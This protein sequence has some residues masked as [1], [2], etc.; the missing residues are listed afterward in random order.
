MLPEMTIDVDI[1]HV[2]HLQKELE[3][4]NRVSLDEI[5]FFDG[6]TLLDIPKDVIDHF[7][8]TGLCNVDFV[9]TGAYTGEYFREYLNRLKRYKEM[10]AEYGYNHQ[11]Q[12]EA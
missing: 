11:D 1:N 2:F 9:T 4:I 7:E 8:L 12:N 3:K 6:E 5:R 10:E